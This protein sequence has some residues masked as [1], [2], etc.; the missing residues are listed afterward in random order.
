MCSPIY[1]KDIT[2][3]S[4]HPE[5]W[6]IPSPQIAFCFTNFYRLVLKILKFFEKH[7]QNLNTS[8]NNLASRDLIRYAKG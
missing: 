7:A 2:T 1:N 8:Q 3:L 5:E 6:L 4:R